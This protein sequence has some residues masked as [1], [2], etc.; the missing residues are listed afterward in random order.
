MKCDGCPM[1]CTGCSF[2]SEDDDGPNTIEV[3]IPRHCAQN[4]P[5]DDCHLTP[6]SLAAIEKAI[7]TG[8]PLYC[9]PPLPRSDARVRYEYRPVEIVR[10]RGFNDK[11][12]TGEGDSE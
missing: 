6:A 10:F 9:L 5:L 1:Y 3:S 11:Q 7:E 8:Q 2:I 12:A 4:I